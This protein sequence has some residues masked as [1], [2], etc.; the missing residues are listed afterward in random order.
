[1]VRVA[2]STTRRPGSSQSRLSAPPPTRRAFPSRSGGL[3]P[4][5]ALKLY[6]PAFGFGGRGGRGAPGAGQRGGGGASAPP[7][8][9]PAADGTIATLD[10]NRFEPLLGCTIGEI[11]GIASGMHM[12]QGRVP[13]VPAPGAGRG[14][15]YRLS[16]SQL[17]KPAAERS[18]FDGVDT[19]LAGLARF[20]GDKPPAALVSGLAAIA[21]RFEAATRTLDGGNA[22]ATVPDL[23]AGLTAARDLL[24]RLDTLGLSDGA[25][26]EIRHRLA[27]KESQIQDAIV[28][29][30]AC[31]ST[32]RPTTGSSSPASRSG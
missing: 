18:L 11:G 27:L 30:Q 28:I 6:R 4:W 14:A 24:A 9:P 16:E 3:R 1:M 15:Q 21:A 31:A 2:A 8:A 32:R 5:Q 17:Q 7:P 20:A 10:T 29:A 19:S 12:C 23:A 26:Y 13:L 22:F 25:A